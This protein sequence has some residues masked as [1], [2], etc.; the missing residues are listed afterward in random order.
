MALPFEDDR[1]GVAVMAL[2]IH[3]VTDP[4]KGIGN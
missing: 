4:A 1:F 2:V 3:F